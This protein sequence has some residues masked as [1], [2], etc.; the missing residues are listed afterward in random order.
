MKTCC[1]AFLVAFIPAA[2]PGTERANLAAAEGAPAAK[3]YPLRGVV[4]K[5]MPESGQVRVKHEAIA[6]Y[7]PAMTMAFHAAPAELARL[8][9]GDTIAATLELRGEEFW[10]SAIKILNR[11]AK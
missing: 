8:Q 7:M 11:P 4:A 6:G 9:A 5:V 2:L 1:L 10:L 3:T